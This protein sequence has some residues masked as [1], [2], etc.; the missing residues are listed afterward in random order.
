[1]DAGGTWEGLCVG[2]YALGKAHTQSTQVRGP[3]EEVT[4]LLLPISVY[5]NGKPSYK[6]LL[7]LYLKNKGKTQARGGR[8]SSSSWLLAQE[9]LS[10]MW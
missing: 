4:P 1:M 3:R 7:E 9:L 6:M 2:I 5:R 8:S 10:L